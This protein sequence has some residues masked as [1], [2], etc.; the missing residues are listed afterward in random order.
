MLGHAWTA[1]TAS[2]LQQR[3]TR[4]VSNNLP[5][6]YVLSRFGWHSKLWL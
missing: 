3:I 1:A 4:V 5:M 2:G 6:G